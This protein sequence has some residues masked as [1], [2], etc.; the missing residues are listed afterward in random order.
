MAVVLAALGLDWLLLCIN[1]L[2]SNGHTHEPLTKAGVFLTI[3]LLEGSLLLSHEA[4]GLARSKRFM[5]HKARAASDAAAESGAEGM[6][7]DF[8]TDALDAKTQ[9]SRDYGET[10]VNTA[11]LVSVTDRSQVAYSHL[12]RRRGRTGHVPRIPSG[13]LL[14][15]SRFLS[16]WCRCRCCNQCRRCCRRG[17]VGSSGCFDTARSSTILRRSAG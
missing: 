8:R 2:A 7:G 16:T 11:S 4:V 13:V 6:S 14:L 12:R 5:N 9:R 1:C 10:I 15:G 3:A 17:F